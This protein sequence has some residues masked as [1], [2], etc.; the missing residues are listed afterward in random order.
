[1]GS[2]TPGKLRSVSPDGVIGQW[3]GPPHRS[4]IGL[5]RRVGEDLAKPGPPGTDASSGR[6]GPPRAAK[7]GPIAGTRDLRGNDIVSVLGLELQRTSTMLSS[8][9]ARRAYF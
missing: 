6:L 3:G 7:G 8:L 4:R 5:R 9:W 2:K 1:M